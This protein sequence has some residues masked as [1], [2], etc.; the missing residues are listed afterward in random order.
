MGIIN[1]M[2]LLCFVAVLWTS[3]V[4][5]AQDAR[6]FPLH[7]SLAKLH[8]HAKEA[9]ME[10]MGATSE[11][12]VAKHHL[13]NWIEAQ[14]D[15]ANDIS[16]AKARSGQINE[17]LKTVQVA[18]PDDEQNLLGSLGEV[19]LI[20]EAGLLIVTTGV[21]ILCQFDESAY[22]YRRVEGHWQRVWESEQNEYVATKYAPQHIV[23]VHVWQSFEGGH[24]NGPAFV[25]TLGNSWGCA[26]T[27]HPVHYKVWRIDSSGQKLLIAGSEGA[28]LRAGSYAVGSIGKDQADRSAPVDVLIEFTQA[29][30][31]AGVHNR[32]AVR[33][34][35]IDGDQVRRV[36][37]VALSPRDFVDEW[38]TRPWNE[39]AAWSESLKL[40]MWHGKLHAVGGEFAGPSLHCE[41]ADL[42][43]VSFET[44][45][46][47]KNFDTNTA[48]HYLTSAIPGSRKAS[49]KHRLRGLFGCIR[50]NSYR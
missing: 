24:E 17:A 38:L 3:G 32:E 7:T 8:A 36:D 9:T 31:D 27:W 25:M 2:R 49:S 16:Q 13:R 34:F 43:Q 48:V 33:H 44:W 28:W 14:L 22:G 23:A 6:L 15:S 5:S 41:I 39:S 40:L 46:A 35:L 47:Q 42:W 20:G 19:R 45:N 12:T 11:L 1:A 29:S 30:I 4:A 37:P 18:G 10:T 26:S 21:G 50:A